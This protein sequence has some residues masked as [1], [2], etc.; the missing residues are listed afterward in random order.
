MTRS[1]IM[2]RLEV[3]KPELSGF[4]IKTL[5]LFGSHA[6]DTAHSGSDIDLFVAFRGKATFDAYMD[7]KLFLE[8]RLGHKNDLVTDRAIRPELRPAIEREAIR[9]A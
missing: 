2:A 4:D 5:Y 3:L 6:R 8:D 7:L 1:D 9:V